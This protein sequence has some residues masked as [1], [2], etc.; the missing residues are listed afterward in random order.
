MFDGFI[1][2]DEPAA[3]EKDRGAAGGVLR[4]S[5]DGS[6]TECMTAAVLVAQQHEG[7]GYIAR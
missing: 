4:Q 7:M 1:E 6:A 3:G 5:Y 2:H